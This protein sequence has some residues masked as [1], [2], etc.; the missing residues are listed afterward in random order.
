V[1]APVWHIDIPPRPLAAAA[2][3][4]SPEKCARDA[5]ERRGVCCRAAPRSPRA[6]ALVDPAVLR[7]A[8]IGLSVR[9]ARAVPEPHPLTARTRRTG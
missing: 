7:D 4:P 8:I 5:P 6:R 1:D 9:P 3:P 2:A